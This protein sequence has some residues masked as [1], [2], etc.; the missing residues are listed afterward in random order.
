MYPVYWLFHLINIIMT[1]LRQWSRSIQLF[2][3]FLV[4]AVEVPLLYFL[5]VLLVSV[6]Y[7][8]KSHASW[9]PTW[10]H[11][12]SDL[13]NELA[14]LSVHLVKIQHS[15]KC[16]SK[17]SRKSKDQWGCALSSWNMMSGIFCN[18]GII[19][20]SHTSCDTK[21]LISANPTHLQLFHEIL[22]VPYF[23]IIYIIYLY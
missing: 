3:T 4:I 13:E 7:Y 16:L 9:N 11:R 18:C 10:N 22:S 14:V 21:H 5:S 12:V 23:T 6:F 20:R 19:K 15:E 2:P 17:Q 1:I 8:D